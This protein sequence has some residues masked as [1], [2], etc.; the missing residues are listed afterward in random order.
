MSKGKEL[1]EFLEKVT[2]Y[3]VETGKSY[4]ISETERAMA[5]RLVNEGKCFYSITVDRI[6][7]YR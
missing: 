4:E 2:K 1:G 7:P 6:I 5:K 3:H